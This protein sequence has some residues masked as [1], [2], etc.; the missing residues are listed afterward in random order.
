M[1]DADASQE[2]GVRLEIC[3]VKLLVSYNIVGQ[4]YV[5]CSIIYTVS[6]KNAHIFIFLITRSNVNQF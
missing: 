1:D 5:V 3:T 2:V 6:Q 4:V